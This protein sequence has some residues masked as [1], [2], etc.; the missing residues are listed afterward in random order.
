RVEDHG[1]RRRERLAL[2]G[3]HLGDAAVVQD[4]PA[5]QLDVEVAH[6]HRALAGLADQAEAFVEQIVERFAAARPLAQGVGGVAQLLIGEVLELR[7]KGVDPGDALLVTLELLGLAHAKRAVQE[8]HEVRV[9]R[10]RR[11]PARRSRRAA[12]PSG[13]ASGSRRYVPRQDLA[14]GYARLA[15]FAPLV[16]VALDLD[17]HFLRAQVD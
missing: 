9:A 2:A 1:E 16:A 4:H 10:G 8:G 3:L 13:A 17:G 11:R 15:P 12:P 5:D 7:F 6:A 14:R